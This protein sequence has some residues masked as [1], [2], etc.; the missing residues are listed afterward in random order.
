MPDEHEDPIEA[1]KRRNEERARRLKERIAHGDFDRFATPLE[2]VDAALPSGPEALEV[3]DADFDLSW[4]P[5]PPEPSGVD[6]GT[7]AAPPLSVTP[8]A[9]DMPPPIPSFTPIGETLMGVPTL[10]PPAWPPAELR[11][12]PPP[13][14]PAEAPVFIPEPPP[15]R[16]AAAP[17]EDA[18][19]GLRITDLDLEVIGD[20]V[21][22]QPWDTAAPMEAA[23]TA[24]TLPPL[25]PMPPEEAIP[26]IPEVELTIG[27]PE[28]TYARREEAVFAAAPLTEEPA[29]REEEAEAIKATI[30][31]ELREVPPAAPPITAR[32]FAAPTPTP[33]APEPVAPLAP[34]APA[35]VPA[36]EAEVFV[37]LEVRGNKVRIERR[38][39]TL[40]AAIE[41]FQAI[42]DRYE[43]R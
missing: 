42:I 10:E 13:E 15:V 24:A 31:A 27:E 20:F 40:A 16:A 36:A 33:V 17:P 28:V 7:P 8:P 37:G 22:P 11:L 23:A 26:P 6:L 41:L 34:V 14:V 5:P 29:L 38:N 9:F 25:P 19:A 4:F 12:E 39:I 30:E 43:N 18:Y 2:A 35:A 1:I 32:V 3:P 21:A